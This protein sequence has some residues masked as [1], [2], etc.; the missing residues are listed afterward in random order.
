M[1]QA[2]P[3]TMLHQ[4]EQAETGKA[5]EADGAGTNVICESACL[6]WARLEH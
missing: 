3:V 5:G 4:V 1:S 6:Y 2:H